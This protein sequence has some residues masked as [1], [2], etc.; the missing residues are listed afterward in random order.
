METP[1]IIA[2]IVVAVTAAAELICLFIFSK[3]KNKIYPLCCT[4]PLYAEDKELSERLDYLSILIEDGSLIAETILFI[5]Y[6]AS[7]EQLKLCSEFCQRYHSAELIIPAEIE[8]KLKKIC[9]L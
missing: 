7:T 6:S 8:E 4:V 5:D 1:E 3:L 9:F 2:I